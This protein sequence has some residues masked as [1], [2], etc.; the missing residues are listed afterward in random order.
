MTEQRIDPSKVTKPIQLLAAW[1]AGL[2]LTDSA[3]LTAATA[4]SKP[5][6]ATG[7][8]VIASIANVPVFLAA[9]FLLQTRFRPEMQE[10]VFYAKYLEQ[11]YSTLTR[12][13]ETVAV[14]AL[15]MAQTPMSLQMTAEEP[16]SG[17]SI[18]VNDLLPRFTDLVKALAKEG[19][20]PSKTFGSTNEEPKVPERFVIAVGDGVPVSLVQRVVRAAMPYGLDGIQMAG[21]G[22]REIHDMHNKRLYLGSYNLDGRNSV[23]LAPEIVEQIMSPSLTE[24]GLRELL[25]SI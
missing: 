7:A 25:A 12:R 2:V 15:P 8:L 6:W 23:K 1:L 24:K 17:I 11:R 21:A 19:I 10:D 22:A 9:L 16:S 3:F 20:H 4:I 5:E 13:T 18:E 14:Q